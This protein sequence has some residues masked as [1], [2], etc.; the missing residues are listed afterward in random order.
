M[1]EKFAVIECYSGTLLNLYSTL[2]D[3]INAAEEAA[4]DGG[5]YRVFKRLGSNEI[6]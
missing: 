2:Q 1:K 5:C 4:E 3:A 6:D